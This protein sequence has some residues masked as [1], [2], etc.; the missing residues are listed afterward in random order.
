MNGTLVDRLR[1]ALQTWSLLPQAVS[2]QAAWW[3][4]VLWM[5]WLGPATMAIFLIAHLVIT[6]DHFHREVAVIAC[7]TLVGLVLDNLLSASGMV[8][9]VGDL[10]AGRS[11]IWLVSIWAGFG[12]TLHHSQ[13]VLVRS[14]SAALMTGALGGPLAYWGGEKLERLS[15]VGVEGWLAVAVLW[16]IALLILHSIVR[17]QRNDPSNRKETPS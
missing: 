6:R 15:V 17:H 12:A 9:Y 7:S 10:L 16:T 11:P 4:C 2:H 13:H 1:P 8:T 14:R 3:A 5:G